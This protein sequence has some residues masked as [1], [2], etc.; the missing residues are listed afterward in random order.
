MKK[1]KAMAITVSIAMILSTFVLGCK[2][3]ADPTDPNKTED[4]SGAGD[5]TDDSNKDDDKKDQNDG[6]KD[7]GSKDDGSQTDPEDD[8]DDDDV[9]SSAAQ[10]KIDNAKAGD[11][12]TLDTAL[13]GSTIKI[14]KKLTVNGSGVEN[15]KVILNPDVADN[16]KLKNFVNASITIKESEEGRRARLARG[17]APDPKPDPAKPREIGDRNKK[18]YFEGC[19]FKKVTAEYDVSIYLDEDANKCDINEIEL[20]DGVKS[21]VVIEDEEDELAKEKKSSIG[22][23]T[24]EKGVEEVELLGGYY[25]DIEFKGEFTAEDKVDFYYDEKGDQVEAAFKSYLAEQ[26]AKVSAKDI[27]NVKNGK[28]IYK[29]T[30]P[31]DEIDNMN[32]GSISIIL[33][34][35]SQK[36]AF[37]ST[38]FSTGGNWKW[39][40]VKEPYFEIT[41][42]GYFMYETKDN[43][44]H[45]ICGSDTSN[46]FGATDT[47]DYYDFYNNY[48]PDGICSQKTS[49]GLEIYL[50]LSKVLKSDLATCAFEE[51]GIDDA[52]YCKPSKL[53]EIDLE[54]YKPYISVNLDKYDPMME[55]KIETL[56]TKY[57]FENSEIVTFPFSK[58]NGSQG[59]KQG[60]FTKMPEGETYPDISNVKLNIWECPFVKLYDGGAKT[61]LSKI[62]KDKFHWDSDEYDFYLDETCTELLWFQNYSDKIVTGE[63]D[64]LYVKPIEKVH[65]YIWDN[66]EYY[67]RAKL[68]EQT[69]CGGINNGKGLY[70]TS[71]PTTTDVPVTNINDIDTSKKYWFCDV[72]TNPAP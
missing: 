54:G 1:I 20:K 38:D 48:S 60:Y 9:D 62:Q 36:Q 63:I 43:D 45:S 14:T 71:N 23:I 21:F 22:K 34:K 66:E 15:L 67:S 58:S 6:S 8:Q 56:K 65:C 61:L 18:F 40:S 59:F 31:A 30:I 49:S 33:M 5:N 70:T 44:V 42:S 28:G 2:E 13:P 29:F 12:V 16:V 24:I 11:T 57:T 41:S 52:Y 26:A 68:W 51:D 17:A 72:P 64:T 32:N 53:T 35:D 39:A 37:T 10:A 55:G 50:D 46:Y 25:K 69:Q 27:C 47:A 7:D 4:S 3:P 19:S